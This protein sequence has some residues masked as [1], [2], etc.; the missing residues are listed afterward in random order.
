MGRRGVSRELL[1][2][3]NQKRLELLKL[4]ER[5]LDGDYVNGVE[6]SV[7][8]KKVATKGRK[9]LISV[10]MV[11]KKGSSKV[12]L[13]KERYRNR[14]RKAFKRKCKMLKQIP[15]GCCGVLL[16]HLEE[17]VRQHLSGA[18]LVQFILP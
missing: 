16:R 18:A 10:P 1:I 6:M 3:P 9:K 11:N 14:H 13:K 8:E 15:W 7:S 5:R 4:R 2:I 17:Q 12:K